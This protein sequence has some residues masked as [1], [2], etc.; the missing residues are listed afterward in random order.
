MNQL[1]MAEHIRC[2]ESRLAEVVVQVVDRERRKVVF[3]VDK[4]LDEDAHLDQP[5]CYAC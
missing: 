3:P 2:K 5:P 1:G 4:S